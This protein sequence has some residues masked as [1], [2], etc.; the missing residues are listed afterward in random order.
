MPWWS[1]PRVFASCVLWS[2]SLRLRKPWPRCAIEFLGLFVNNKN[3]R[4]RLP[5][6]KA[7]EMGF[8]SRYF[9]RRWKLWPSP[10]SP[11]P[12]NR[13]QAYRAPSFSSTRPPLFFHHEDP[14]HSTGWN[15][16]GDRTTRSPLS[17][18]GRS[19]VLARPDAARCYGRAVS[20]AE[21]QPSVGMERDLP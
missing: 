10:P 9:Q 19:P 7:L 15:P 17:T 2:V 4:H 12:R 21:P 11:Q 6:K 1:I 18:R 13:L 8:P 5:F 20:D 16:K 14:N 3:W